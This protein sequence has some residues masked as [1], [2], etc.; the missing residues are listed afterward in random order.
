MQEYQAT[1]RELLNVMYDNQDE[2]I[3]EFVYQLKKF[4]LFDKETFSEEDRHRYSSLLDVS[5]LEEDL[6]NRLRIWR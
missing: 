5:V 2:R 6:R 3:M 1:G 4:H